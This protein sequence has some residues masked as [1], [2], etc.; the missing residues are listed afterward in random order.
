MSGSMNVLTKSVRWQDPSKFRIVFN[1]SGADKG[2]FDSSSIKP[3]IMSMSCTGI[4]LA[5]INSTPIEEFTAEEWRFATGRL[6][7]YQLQIGFKDF[8]NYSLYRTFAG[9]IQKFL[10]EYPDSQKFD[11]SISVA[12]DFDIKNF[13][14]L[15]T[16]KDCIL[17]AVSG[18]T[19]DNS[20]VASIAEFQVT[21]KCSYVE[22]A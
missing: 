22:L 4:Q 17:I 15:L 18:A 10:R 9:A 19:L 20:A 14:H 11:V 7:N 21:A 8:N 1:G 5:D 3:E 6:E 2:N 13:K 16:Y 12:D